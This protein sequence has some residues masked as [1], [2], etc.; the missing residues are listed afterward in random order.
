MIWYPKKAA[1]RAGQV[2][3]DHW[4]ESNIGIESV[5]MG[6]DTKASGSYSTAIGVNCQASGTASVSMGDYNVSSGI[7]ST[8]LGSACEATKMS[9]T[10]IGHSSKA[11]GASS[12]AIGNEIDAEAFNSFVIGRYNVGGGDPYLWD[13]FDPLFEIGNGNS[14]TE[15]SNALTI[16]KNGNMGINT[17]MPSYELEVDGSVMATSFFGDGSGLTG[18]VGDNLGDHTATENVKL[19]GNWLSYDGG[20]EGIYIQNDGDVGIGYSNPM[21]KLVVRKQFS[22]LSG[23]ENIASIYREALG[24]PLNGIGAGLVF[25]CDVLPGLE[26]IAGRVSGVME[27]V[28]GSVSKGGLLFQPHGYS[29]Y[30]DAMYLNGNG[31]VGIGTLSP[32]T[33]LDVNGTVKATS[34]SGD[35]SGL[36]GISGDNMGNH[37]AT[38]NIKLSGEWLSNDGGNE[39]VSIANDGEVTISEGLFAN[40]GIYVVNSGVTTNGV[41]V[42]MSEQDGFNVRQA[43]NPSSTWADGNNNGFEVKGAQGHGLFVGQTDMDGVHIRKAGS[44][45]NTSSSTLDNGFEVEGA[46]GNG[47]YVGHANNNGISINTASDNGV[48]IDDVDD[49]GVHVNTAGAASATQTSSLDNGFEVE[50]AAGNGLFVGQSDKDGV[51]IHKAGTASTSIPSASGYDNGIE[52]AGAED[53]GVYIGRSD[54]DGIYINS[55]GDMGIYINESADDGLHIKKAG[56]TTTTTSSSYNNGVEIEGAQGYGMYIGH[57]GNSGVFVNDA[58]NDGVYISD[59]A[60][61]GIYVNNAGG[62][63]IKVNTADGNG[64]YI[65]NA[66]IRGI[67]VSADDDGVYVLSAGNSSYQTPSSYKNGFEVAGAEGY[68]LYVGRANKDGVHVYK[69]GN[70]TTIQSSSNNNGFEVEGTDGHGLYVG[71]A[72]DYGVSIKEANTGFYVQD[73]STIGVRVVNAGTKGVYVGECSDGLCVDDAGDDGLWIAYAGDDAMN[74]NTTNT[75]REWALYTYDKIHAYNVTSKGSSSYAKN[76]GNSTLEP[77]DIVCIA[78]GLENYVL[79][80]EGHPVVNI[81]KASESNSQAVFGVVEYKVGIREEYV[82]AQDSESQELRK[83]FEHADGNVMQGNYLSVIVF[84]Q[85]EVKVNNKENIKSGE[86]LS[87]SD[88]G[89]RKIRTTEINGI[90][91]AENVGIL[92]KALEDSNG[93]EKIM[94]FVNCK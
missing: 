55:A 24:S 48:F 6:V 1:F 51:Y 10:A 73:A 72:D 65:G 19:S 16:L 22:S 17:S 30:K 70:P 36:T 86:A 44:P 4:D 40:N 35:G 84:G 14:D 88:N 23:I 21:E 29:G 66:G 61:D 12:T 58:D 42:N 13:Q 50:G 81:S 93:K 47:L 89:V 90:T 83:R 46:S 76:T 33:E 27:V 34:F 91:I 7:Y 26:T 56:T 43:G 94:V 62:E 77:G 63:G 20:N 5:A 18:I 68:G 45:T 31:D 28:S 39:G 25:R 9:S 60:D 75:N 78:G 41:F 69:A 53:Y 49:D 85:A 11:T 2:Y 54:N 74:V 67:N 79:N 15:R 32:S 80:G 38:Q 8:T 37:T 64:L 92:G 57:S 87:A 3:G 59:A 71:F 52:V 82:K